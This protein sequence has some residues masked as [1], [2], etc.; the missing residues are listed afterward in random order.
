LQTIWIQMKP[1][2]MWG[3]IWDPNCLTFRLYII[4]KNGWKQWIFLKFWKK[5]IFEKNTQHAKSQYWSFRGFYCTVYSHVLLQGI[6]AFLI[7]KPT[8][9]LSL[10]QKE[11]KLG[12]RA[13]STCNLIFDECR[14]PKDNLLG[15]PGFGFKIAM[16]GGF[17]YYVCFFIQDCKV[18]LHIIRIHS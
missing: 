13:S 18:F 6:S 5:Q 9:G 14:I 12:I 1:H 16:V 2:K 7:P 17:F 3:F 10:G 15:E 4:K 8:P 11:S